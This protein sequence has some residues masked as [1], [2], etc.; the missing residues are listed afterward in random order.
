M[1]NTIL[2]IIGLL[3]VIFGFFS[4]A[5]FGMEGLILVIIGVAIAFY[6]RYKQTVEEKEERQKKQK[7]GKGI[8]ISTTDTI[9]EKKIV[10]MLGSIQARNNPFAITLDMSENAQRN[11]EKEAEKIEANAIVGMK[12]ERQQHKK[13]ITYFAY[14]TAVIVEDEK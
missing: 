4:I 2:N 14:G 5:R 1:K 9:P 13:S 8:I 10:K 7:E 12:I 11:L 6:G 3:I